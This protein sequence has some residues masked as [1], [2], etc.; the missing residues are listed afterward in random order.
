[1]RAS[2]RLS[3]GAELSTTACRRLSARASDPLVAQNCSR[4]PLIIDPKL[5]GIRWIREREAPNNLIVCQLTQK[6]YLE[7]VQHAMPEVCKNAAEAIRATH[8]LATRAIHYRKGEPRAG[9]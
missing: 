1:M 3:A 5:Q 6:N 9:W 7:R 8:D 2:R 4:Y